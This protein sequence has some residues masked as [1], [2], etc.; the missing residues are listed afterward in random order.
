MDSFVSPKDEIWFSARVPS[1]FNRSIPLTLHLLKWR[2][3]RAP[4]NASKGQ[5]GFD[6]A[7]KGLNI[8]TDVRFTEAGGT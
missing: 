2:I 6:S 3:W 8:F 4:N 1:R 7:F 5:M